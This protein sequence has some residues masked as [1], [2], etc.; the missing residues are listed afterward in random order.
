MCKISKFLIVNLYNRKFNINT[1]TEECSR[2]TQSSLRIMIFINFLYYKITPTAI[3]FGIFPIAI[4][5]SNDNLF[6]YLSYYFNY[7]GI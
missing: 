6:S 3:S 5:I 7:T 4:Y 1:I 2:L